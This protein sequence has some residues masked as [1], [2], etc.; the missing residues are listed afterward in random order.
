[1][2]LEAFKSSFGYW[3]FRTN[4]GK[5]TEE[6]VAYLKKNGYRWS[7][8]NGC[9]YPATS[10]AKENNLHGDFAAEIQ[11]K[12]DEERTA[13]ERNRREL[14]SDIIEQ[15]VDSA[16]NR[17][18]G[19]E[20]VAAVANSIKANAAAERTVL[21]EKLVEKLR[22]QIRLDQEKIQR[23]E[24]E[25]AERGGEEEAAMAEQEQIVAEAEW[26]KENALTEEEERAVIEKHAEPHV[27]R[28]TQTEDAL[29]L[30][31]E[32]LA[33]A[34]SVMPDAQYR[35]TLNLSQGEEREFFIGKLKSLAAAVNNAPKI[36]DGDG[37]KEHPIVFRYFHPTGTETLVTEIGA[38]GEAYG[39][40][41]LN[42]DYEMAEWGYLDLNEIKGIRMMEIDYH[43]PEGMTVEKWLYKNHPEEFPQYAENTKAKVPEENQMEES[44]ALYDFSRPI[45]I[46]D[47]FAI[48]FVDRGYSEHTVRFLDRKHNQVTTGQYLVSTIAEHKIG[49][50]L[51]LD[52]LVPAWTVDAEPMEKAIEICKYYKENKITTT[53]NYEEGQEI[54][55]AEK[56]PFDIAQETGNDIEAIAR[57]LQNG[58]AVEKEVFTPR[59]VA[60][61]NILARMDFQ[62]EL[63]ENGK[64]MVY[65][66]QRGEYLDNE[67]DVDVDK[68]MREF[69][70]A[71]EVFD[72]MD[73][74]IR[75]TYYADMQEDLDKIG[76]DTSSAASLSDIC[77]LY[78]A[79]IEK[80]Q[81][82][83]S[84]TILNWALG[85]VHPDTVVMP[86]G[87]VPERSESVEPIL[88]QLSI[89][90]I[91]LNNEHG[92]DGWNEQDMF[93]PTPKYI[94]AA[95]ISDERFAMP[96][97]SWKNSDNPEITIFMTK[98]LIAEPSNAEKEFLDS[99]KNGSPTIYEQKKWEFLRTQ[100][101]IEATYT[102]IKKQETAQ[103]IEKSSDLEK[104]LIDS[105]ILENTEYK[106]TLQEATEKQLKEAFDFV[107]ENLGAANE[108]I[109]QE[110]ASISDKMT[111][112][113]LTPKYNAIAEELGRRKANQQINEP[114]QLASKKDIK[115]IRE[116][117][118]EILKKPDAE[119][120]EAEKA[121]LA[122]YEGA[123][124]LNEANRSNAG[125]LNEFYTPNNLVEKVW[126]IVDHYAPNAKTVLEP[127]AGVGKFANNRPNNEFTMHEL[128]ETSARIN[129]ILHPDANIVQG[130]YQKQFFDESERFHVG[131]GYK[132][133]KYDIVIGNPPY[134]EYSDKWK[135]LGEG[136]LF[137][138]YEEYFIA[139]GLD[140]LKD[141]NSLLAF[142]VPSG[143]L[144]TESDKQ[145]EFL[146]TNGK[147]ID[148]YRL[149][150]G[151][152]PTTEVGTD[153]VVFQKWKSPKEFNAEYLENKNLLC[154][155]EWFNQHPE[156]VLGEVKTRTNRF[157]RE[158]EYVTAHEGLTVQ[159]ELNKIA[160]F[161]TN[162]NNIEKVESFSQESESAFQK[163]SIDGINEA[164]EKL[165]YYFEYSDDMNVAD[166]YKSENGDWVGSYGDSGFGYAEDILSGDESNKIP[167]E[168]FRDVVS[169]ADR[170]F[171]ANVELEQ[172]HAQ[173]EN[174]R[175]D[176][177][178]AENKVPAKPQRPQKWG[179]SKK[180]GEL[181]TS[182]EFA[183]LYGR[184]FDAR[185]F[186]IWKATDWQG[187]IDLEKLS[188]A[189]IRYM[190]ESGEY[191]QKA[192]GVW[193]HKELFCSGDIY[194]KIEEQKSLKEAFIQ[195]YGE[196]AVKDMDFDKNIAL[197]ES[198]KKPPLTM[199]NIH[200]GLKTP[201]AES[202]KT[203][204][205]DEDGNAVELN[206]Q[207]SF[208]LWAQNSTLAMGM[209][210][211][212]IDFA[213]A[214]IS[215]EELGETV[216][217][218]DIVEYI[219]GEPVKANALR[220]WRASKMT[221]DEKKAE[222]AERKKEADLKR[223]TRSDVANRLFDRYLHEGITGET[224]ARLEAEYNRRFNSYIAPDYSKLPLFVDG[225]SAWKGNSKFKLYDQQIKGISF[226]CNKGNGLLAYDV[227][228][229]KTAAGITATENQ[230]QLGR[231]KRP[232]I[233]VPNQVYSKWYTDIKQLF[234]KTKIN[235]LYNFGRDSIAKFV[236]PNDP[237]KLNL[238]ENSISLC[239]YE[240][241]K[242]I[243]FKDESCVGPLFEDFKDLLSA[244]FDGSESE[245]AAAKEKIAGVIGVSS[246]VK[247]PNYV[248]FEDCGFDHITVDE[249]HNFKNLWVVPRPKKKGQSNE[250][251]GIPS[252]K[253]SNRALKM[254]AMTQLVQ[255]NNNDRNVFMLTA[256]PFTNSPTEVYSMLSY[257]GRERL[258]QSGIDS[259][260][261]FFEEFAQTKQELGVTSSGEIDTKQV[262]KNW[263]ELPA[264]Q[265]ILTEFIDKVDG[266]EAGII[267]PNKYTHVKPLDMS[268]LQKEMRE[269]DEARMAGALG[270]ESTSADTIVAMNNMRLSCVAPALA[271]PAMYPGVKLPSMQELV[272]TSPKLKFV[273]DAIIDM[274]KEN[275]EKGQ[276]MYVPLGKDSHGIIK[277]YLVQHGIPKEA[278]EIINGE[279]NNSVEK[280][281]K[282]TA[283]FNDEKSKLKILIGGRNTAEGID[284]NGNSFVMYN[285]SLGWNPSETVQAEGR[286]WRQGNLQGNVHIVYPVMN[287]SIDSVLYQ[288]HDE[289]ISR[290]GELWSY[291]GDALNVEDINPE[292]LKLDLIKDPRKKANLILKEETK[293]IKAELS[294]VELKIKD[295]DDIVERRQQM[296]LDFNGARDALEYHEGIA[297]KEKEI[298]NEI[299]DW[300]KQEIKRDRQAVA[301]YES[302]KSRMDERLAALNLITD[303]DITEYV[304]G[305]NNQK[306][307]LERQ[308]KDVEKKLPEILAKLE[309]ER[310][311]QKLMEYPVEK[312]REILEA[313]IL[314]NLRPMKEVE[315]E[316]RTARHEAMLDAMLKAG[317][318][319]QEEHD[320]YKAAGW[321]KYQK[322]LDGEIDSLNETTQTVEVATEEEKPTAEPVE[323]SESVEIK[324]ASGLP[325]KEQLAELKTPEMSSAAKEL[326]SDE[327]GLFFGC[328]TEDMFV[329]SPETEYSVQETVDTVHARLMSNKEKLEK[330]GFKYNEEKRS[331][332]KEFNLYNETTGKFDKA[333]Y[334]IYV[335]GDW[336]GTWENG[337]YKHVRND[338]P[339][340]WTK[341][342][343]LSNGT[344]F[345]GGDPNVKEGLFDASLG[346]AVLSGYR[347]G[348][349]ELGDATKFWMEQ[350]EYHNYNHAAVIFGKRMA[351][352]MAKTLRN[353]EAAYSEFMHPYSVSDS[354]RFNYGKSDLWLTPDQL[355]KSE[356]RRDEIVLPILN[357]KESG[358]YKAFNNFAKRGV[359]DIVGQKLDLQSEG[360]ISDEGW[361]QLR[362]AM[363]IYRDKRFETMRYVL[364]DKRTGEIRDQLAVSSKMPNISL[365]I[366]GADMFKNLVTRAEETNCMICAVH[367]HPS[368]RTDP[369]VE[370]ME[371]TVELN[372]MFTNQLTGKSLFAGHIILDHGTYS[373]Y[374]NKN[375]W[376]NVVDFERL[377]KKDSMLNDKFP[378]ANQEISNGKALSSVAE[379]VNDINNWND[380]FVP[381]V[382]TDGTSVKGVKLY[383]VSFFKKE[384]FE[385]RTELQFAGLEAGAVR[386]FPVY[387]EA[388]SQKLG[389]MAMLFEDRLEELVRLN[390]FT[391][392]ALPVGQ[393]G[394]FNSVTEKCGVKPGEDFFSKHALKSKPGV[395]ATWESHIN[396]GLFSKNIVAM[397][398]QEQ[399]KIKAKK[400]SGM[401]Y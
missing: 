251:A 329:K 297:K 319:T 189:D 153:I 151:T 143:F 192:A 382:F 169:L 205:I 89:E 53:S 394:K 338:T 158:E 370:D 9:W 5:P 93:L 268:E 70:S 64:L 26:E 398:D 242:N 362:A 163:Q 298:G 243:T 20:R 117:C 96:V 63:S 352:S 295:F 61:E 98:R 351:N 39:F 106:M 7:K 46:S 162:K 58:G 10:E 318:I 203:T 159:D 90:N 6:M 282:I 83:L 306:H 256:T 140:A 327:G 101:A 350:A 119:I 19:K 258:K 128:D 172:E 54:E 310:L 118:R 296:S 269:I 204:H 107:L 342:T 194:A 137:D 185:V 261:S 156:K 253:P 191:V 149:P 25:L 292:D 308:I 88:Q 359:F 371:T 190:S 354:M 27:E 75:D 125:I 322:W 305:L 113:N 294:S 336:K 225:M 388:L 209:W 18:L 393:N 29:A 110:E 212:D 270:V 328:D 72:R 333:L 134:G 115:K 21:L 367:N 167:D 315:W 323:Q 287:D 86:K 390:A 57:A 335:A 177:P 223:Q 221:E 325:T 317:D 369:S 47:R 111:I 50:G 168:V 377:G 285:C 142:V 116:Q 56:T 65:D 276:F 227:G 144:N 363:D 386:A 62:L 201:L 187:N 326:A 353:D 383:D 4:N 171:R 108:N 272:E 237:H 316:V 199:D 345:D 91:Q 331:F 186:P 284:L 235:D 69:N 281:E 222:K 233:V 401:G 8:N 173:S 355:K 290:I 264:L 52:G 302:G 207:E 97:A 105:Y 247:N 239:T 234:P 337:E 385:I 198:V 245:N 246:Q 343:N 252:G 2:E 210:R 136:K 278:V 349:V 213:S 51:P 148:A 283:S 155:G 179:V 216:S 206:L 226:L 341:T 41:C 299:P 170:F 37:A 33:A 375:G 181:M 78:R 217:F 175:N 254:F 266:E 220:G 196:N 289:K 180:Q 150:E 28:K 286:I 211:K 129:K 257:I 13:L 238:P 340:L 81:T 68:A 232:L 218:M 311:E 277:D 324:T 34:R 23:Y 59:P 109:R 267:R 103:N 42:G 248:F 99:S 381:V 30:S 228:V 250:Y 255:R 357:G 95:K 241:L 344:Y 73:S 17:E 304:H 236:D 364:V 174:D 374:T 339:I 399:E 400:Y 100:D 397:P 176:A 74:F 43:V 82:R 127:S 380:D 307:K 280:K 376:Q 94:D 104:N 38:D 202:F 244:D 77:E 274:Y 133:P 313:D 3:N 126:Q 273:C 346:D 215:R 358:M 135:G 178:Q 391:D 132:Q 389:A 387:T 214:N 166:I 368:G 87:F 157:G 372:K 152:F 197:L 265:S 275:P 365:A 360:K 44:N 188:A 263:K 347:R 67:N 112:K 76:V 32:E 92:E 379:K 229:G 154:N 141:E 139:K 40:Q 120:T 49:T 45:V 124:G 195:R 312:Q 160:G 291:K 395:E 309:T 231:S 122:Q 392:A 271:N 208:I 230:M 79:E 240:A 12:F 130:A 55:D 48:D 121:I 183:R 330:I 279:I 165:G 164:A 321:E 366:T 114:Q 1:M 71:E 262:M 260:R 314:N 288:K 182:E 84:E 147:L 300:L 22:E 66:T 161:L 303:D 146:A 219:D 301:R 123:G 131:S 384:A 249:A 348:V 102:Q 293:G 14:P 378:L 60:L 224:K 24:A 80:G 259:L 85:I 320:L 193:T 332:E 138:R 145:K 200:F 396:P 334:E 31:P 356:M 11:R 373:L 361:A 36:G 16:T 184:E 35:T 15:L